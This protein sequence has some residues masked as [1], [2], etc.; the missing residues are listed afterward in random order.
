[1]FNSTS[2]YAVTKV[3][4]VLEGES[5]EYLWFGGEYCHEFNQM[6]YDGLDEIVI[7][8]LQSRIILDM[9]QSP[10]RFNVIKVIYELVDRSETKDTD[11]WR[12]IRP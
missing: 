6:G 11:E 8:I 10:K 4:V 2:G 1:M 9:K 12:E 5:E 3:N 7:P